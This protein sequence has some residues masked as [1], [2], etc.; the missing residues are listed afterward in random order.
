MSVEPQQ[1]SGTA[2]PEGSQ[3]P[4][5]QRRKFHN[6]WTRE[7]ENLF[8]D[9]ADKAA[10]FRWMH[11]R[12]ERNFSK[13]D[14]SFMFPIIILST[15]TGAANFALDSVIQGEEAKTYAQLG[16]GSLSILTGILTTIANRLGYASGSEAHR[17]AAISWGKFNRFICIEL[18]LHPNERM[19]SMA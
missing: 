13:A 6:G 11:E 5:P 14:Q 19:D 7:L 17:G 10:C 1:A 8:A 15:V 9:W 16:L 18:S 4:P 12:T 2:T 3:S